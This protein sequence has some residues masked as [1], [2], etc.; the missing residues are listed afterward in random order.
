MTNLRIIEHITC[1]E[2]F[3]EKYNNNKIYNY[4]T[5]SRE[6]IEEFFPYLSITHIVFSDFITKDETFMDCFREYIDYYI[7]VEN[8]ICLNKIKKILD[9]HSLN[10]IP[11]KCIED[12]SNNESI[13]FSIFIKNKD[14]TKIKFRD[15][16]IEINVAIQK[17]KVF[18]RQKTGNVI[19][20][21]I[22]DVDSKS[23]IG[24]INELLIK[25]NK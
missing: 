2:E 12:L 16:H 17:E 8:L 20:I 5:F 6:I 18:I 25:N 1:R 13:I 19:F 9:T 24:G 21:N 3:I 4:N 22:K 14:L 11:I 15:Y 23:L 7:G 10:Y